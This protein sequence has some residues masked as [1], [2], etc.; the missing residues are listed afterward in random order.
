MQHAVS[1]AVPDSGPV[2][3]G[4]LFLLSLIVPVYLPV[5]DLLLMPHGIV[6]LILFI[7]FFFQLFVRGGAGPVLAR[8]A[9][10]R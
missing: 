1:R 2:W 5:G 6:I 8:R 4:Q 3:A 7:P 10:R 9:R